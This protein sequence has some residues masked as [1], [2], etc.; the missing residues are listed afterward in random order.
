[1][2]RKATRSELER[3]EIV[4][5]HEHNLST[6]HQLSETL[7]GSSFRASCSYHFTTAQNTHAISNVEHLFELVGNEDDGYALFGEIT[8]Y[9]EQL[10]GFLRG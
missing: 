3:I 2:A 1:M 8:H 4:G 6:D 10:V 9:P 5:A 7:F